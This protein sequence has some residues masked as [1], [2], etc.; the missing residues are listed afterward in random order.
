MTDLSDWHMEALRALANKIWGT[1]GDVGRAA[2]PS[3]LGVT[4]T[5]N[6]GSAL[7]QLE[8]CGFCERVN[9]K[10]PVGWR[11]TDAGRA[12]LQPHGNAS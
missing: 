5:H 2:W 11:I 9:A 12:A 6:A 10:S 8:L 4:A 3:L 7:R 1:A